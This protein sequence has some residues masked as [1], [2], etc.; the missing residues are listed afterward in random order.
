MEIIQKYSSLAAPAMDDAG[1]AGRNAAAAPLDAAGEGMGAA[2]KTRFEATR[3]WHDALAKRRD[4]HLAVRNQVEK[5][6]GR[7]AGGVD[8]R[9]LG[10]L[11]ESLA[12]AALSQRLDQPR[13]QAARGE[14]ANLSSRNIRSGENP[15]DDLADA[16]KILADAIEASENGD[17]NDQAT[18]LDRYTKLYQS[19]SDILAKLGT[20]VRADDDNYMRVDFGSLKSALQNLLNEYRNPTQDQVIAGAPSGGITEKE[21]KAICDRLKLDPGQCCHRNTD[22]TYCVIPDMSQV[23]KMIEALPS[24]GNNEKISIASYNAWK[25]GFDSQMSRVEDA[26]QTRGQRYSNCYSRFE[27]FYKTVSAIIDSMA[28]MARQCLQF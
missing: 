7:A 3:D 6:L 5:A 9:H 1:K 17:L 26:L 12:G 8:D 13:E 23:E 10:A 21:A 11:C 28:N 22:G 20:W 15:A 19:L 14:L 2:G 27:N 18:A 4:A 25:A 16:W 24:G